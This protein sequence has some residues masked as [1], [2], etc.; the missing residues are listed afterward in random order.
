MKAPT[1]AS[2][3]GVFGTDRSI[4]LICIGIALIF[5]LLLKLS[6]PFKSQSTFS[7]TYELPEGRV[8]KS[9]P[10]QK[11]LATIEGR[12]WVLLSHF[13]G[14]NDLN[15]RLSLARTAQ[16]TFNSSILKDK[17]QQGLNAIEVKDINLDYIQ[18][19]LDEANR[20]Q[21]P[22]KL[23]SQIDFK[24]G[25]QLKDSIRIQPDSIWL[26]GPTS[27]LAEYD[28]WPTEMLVLDRLTTSQQQLVN[29]VQPEDPVV[30]IDPVRC[31]VTIPVEQY[32]EKSALFVPLSI[33]NASDSIK[34][35]PDRIEV[36]C[37]VG[38]SRF[39]DL[40]SNQFE[41]MVD[42]KNVRLDTENNTL[43]IILTKA[44]DYVSNVKYT[45]QSVE[46]F[47]VKTQVDP[48]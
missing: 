41:L 36:S 12:G 39:N 2:L 28:A 48:Q 21:L 8:F 22:V 40:K 13:L 1:R 38:L 35:F 20:R 5:W 32:T 3:Q 19:Q 25:F 23:E 47:F 43:P 11:I 16:Q 42:L 26:S 27:V 46:F 14:R 9:T 44:P 15:I 29:F 6:Q 30:R 34:I 37:I 17:I 4:L 31:T 33:R 45:P 7:I 24:P 10:P 18:I